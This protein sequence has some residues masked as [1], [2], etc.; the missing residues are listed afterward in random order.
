[1]INCPGAAGYV[2]I[3]PGVIK[4]HQTLQ[5]TE[6][7]KLGFIFSLLRTFL[8]CITAFDIGRLDIITTILALQRLV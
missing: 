7:A 3:G 4:Y 5:K 1:M 8:R 6:N 2:K